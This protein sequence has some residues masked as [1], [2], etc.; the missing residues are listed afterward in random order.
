MA[1]NQIKSNKELKLI[2]QEL[3]LND[4]VM[5][6][7]RLK[8]DRQPNDRQSAKF[9]ARRYIAHELATF[10]KFSKIQPRFPLARNPPRSL[11]VIP[12]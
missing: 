11:N 4:Q 8:S 10:S 7:K 3:K 5:E 12:R 9:V 6:I 1:I 2:E